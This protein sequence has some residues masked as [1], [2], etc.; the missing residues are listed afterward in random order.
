MEDFENLVR[1]KLAQAWLTEA[2]CVRHNVTIYRVPSSFRGRDESTYIPQLVSLDPYHHGDQRLA[3]MEQHKWLA[4]IHVLHRCKIEMRCYITKMKELEQPT[5]DC[6]EGFIDMKSD[7]FV[8]MMV[9]DG[10]FLSEMLLG[11]VNGFVGR[12]HF[13]KDPIFSKRG[14]L[15][16]HQDILMMENQIPGFVVEELLRLQ[17]KLE[18]VIGKLTRAVP[19]YFS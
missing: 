14:M 9:L 7:E 12:G 11:A 16:I 15:S 5:R 18:Y 4:V 8:L 17:L 13:E 6:Y 1:K 19:T 2:L 10:L 3:E